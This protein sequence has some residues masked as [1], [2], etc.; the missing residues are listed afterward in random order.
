M[1]AQPLHLLIPFALVS[2][3]DAQ[4]ALAKL[5]YPALGALLARASL[6]ERAT[7]EDFQRT[8]PHERWLASR[9]GAIGAGA[10]PQARAAPPA[11]SASPA[12]GG[13]DAPLA[14]YMML[15]EGGNPGDARWAVVEPA[16]I[17]IAHDHLVL[18]EP[19][20]LGLSDDECATLLDAARPSFDALGV[21]VEAPTLRRWYVS[22]DALGTLVAAPPLRAAGRSIEIWLPHDAQTGDRSRA[23]MKLQNEVQMSW[24]EHPLNRA[25]ESRGQPAI[26]GLWL[27]AQGTRRAALA[28]PHACVL[29]RALA[30][31]GLGIASGARV[32]APPDT[33]S[34][35]G[36][37]LANASRDD[38]ASVSTNA[39][40][41]TNSTDATPASARAVL[42]ELDALA[43]PYV[44]Q[45]WYTWHETLARY[46][47]DWFAPAL[48]ALRNGTLPALT[49]TLTGDTGAAT[50][51]LTRATLRMFWRRRP[52]AGAMTE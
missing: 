17:Q 14:P 16:H 27:Y 23:W 7:G 31:R 24:F 33:L 4:V 1:P 44:Q 47:R 49:L 15:A 43:T 32:G 36:A 37:A 8:L 50:F 51:A 42:V 20:A 2:A 39:A 26:N 45:D 46:E 6:V 19:D 12:S 13:D 35:L 22:G 10:G 29:S 18:I 48:A 11:G 40:N 3:A 25:R 28:R 34:G 41:A 21:R 30:T 38:A 5:D 52:L 9:F